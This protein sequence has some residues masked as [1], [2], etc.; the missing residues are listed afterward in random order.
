MDIAWSDFLR[1]TNGLPLIT[2]IVRQRCPAWDY[3]IR[4]ARF[5]D[6][7]PVKAVLLSASQPVTS[8]NGF[9]L[10]LTGEDLKVDLQSGRWKCDI[11]LIAGQDINGQIVSRHVG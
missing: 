1:N 5:P 4:F 2:I 10:L 11:A 3:L 8:A 9:L 6:L 7:N